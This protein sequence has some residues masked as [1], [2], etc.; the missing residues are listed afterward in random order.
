MADLCELMGVQKIQTSPYHP[1]TNGQCER[2][3]STLI[4][5]LETLP[6]EKKSEWKNHIGTL[7]HAYNYTCNSATG[8][9][10]YYIMFGRQPHLP[11]D[12]VLVLVPCTIMEP[13]TTKFIQKLREH[14]KW[15]HK[16]AEA[17]QAKEV[18]RH[19]HNYNKRSRAAALEVGD[20]VLVSVTAFKGCHKMQDRWENREYEVEKWLQPNIPVYVVCSRDGEGH[21]WTLHRNYLLPINSNMEQDRADGTEE[22]VK[23]NTSLTPVPSADNNM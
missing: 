13:N 5:M 6:K 3:N 1:Q 17:F 21:S 4:N 15:A 9:S 16:K 14:T 11:V 10:P 18:L 8:F 20:M 7:V 19:K 22:R 2:F 12:V 23:N